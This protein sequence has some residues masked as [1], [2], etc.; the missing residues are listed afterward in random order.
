MLLRR[1]RSN[2]EIYG[3]GL[4]SDAHVPVLVLENVA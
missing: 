1:R 4:S 3:P 2:E